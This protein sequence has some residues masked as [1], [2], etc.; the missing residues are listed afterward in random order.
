MTVIFLL[1]Q[2]TKSVPVN[3]EVVMM[4][5]SSPS[6]VPPPQSD[7]A[8]SSPGVEALLRRPPF[9]SHRFV[10][11][12]PVQTMSMIHVPDLQTVYSM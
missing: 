5:M 11:A 12:S 6:I 10:G 2:S 1:Q 8:R 9:P 4:N 3:Q 7:A